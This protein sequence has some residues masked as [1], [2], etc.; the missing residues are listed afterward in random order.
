MKSHPKALIQIKNKDEKCF[1]RAVVVAIAE[2]RKNDSLVAKNYYENDMCRKRTKRDKQLEAATVLMRSA[3][4]EDHEGPCGLE[5]WKQME[6]SLERRYGL[7]IWSKDY[8]GGILYEGRDAGVFLNLF[9]YDSHFLVI[10]S[11]ETFLN[12]LYF[13][14]TCLKGYNT[15]GK[16]KCKH[17]CK[18]CKQP[19]GNCLSEKG[20]RIHCPD[21]N[22]WF[23]SQQCFNNHTR[24][25]ELT[26][27][28]EKRSG[29]KRFKVMESACKLHK[30]CA[31]CNHM[32]MDG[33]IC[34]KFKCSNCKLDVV[35][36]KDHQF[37]CF[38][39]KLSE[40]EKKSG[41][42]KENKP[43]DKS[44]VF[45]DFESYQTRE[46]SKDKHGKS[47]LAH[48]PNYCVVQKVCDL[49]KDDDDIW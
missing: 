26:A 18:L 37:N 12:R 48:D 2:K 33:H 16:H 6:N 42:E 21:C 7:R 10:T 11:M 28:E 40:A 22:V 17:T 20:V 25:Y 15:I 5:E 9:L 34:F 29:V 1:S 44:F 36:E 35:N 24:E 31:N 32:K 30:R 14:G 38:M 13:C 19:G 47:V 4:L 39:Q 27:G 45:F 49:C 41:E 3:G 8:C 46:L 43:F 23:T